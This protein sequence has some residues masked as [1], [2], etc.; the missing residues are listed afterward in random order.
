M[1]AAFRSFAIVTK[2]LLCCPAC[3][4]F[5]VNNSWVNPSLAS[6]AGLGNRLEN[7]LSLK[8]AVLETSKKAIKPIAANKIRM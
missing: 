1:S 3:L 7:S 6:E 2:S 8:S 4:L 5:S